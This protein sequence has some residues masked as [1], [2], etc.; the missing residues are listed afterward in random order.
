LRPEE[1]S[2]KVREVI[3]GGGGGKG[4]T[5]TG[6]SPDVTQVDLAADIAREFLKL[7]LGE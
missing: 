4:N 2:A 5:F 1:W 7:T 6:T 3:G